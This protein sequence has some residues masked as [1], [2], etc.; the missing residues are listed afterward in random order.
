MLQNQ[1]PDTYPALN[2]AEYSS[3]DNSTVSLASATLPQAPAPAP[4]S[5]AQNTA[6]INHAADAQS[7]SINAQQGFWR[8]GNLIYGGNVLLTQNIRTAPAL[9]GYITAL[10]LANEDLTVYAVNVAVDNLALPGRNVT[11]VAHSV[12]CARCLDS[13]KTGRGCRF[14]PPPA[15]RPSH[16][17]GPTGMET[18]E[19]YAGDSALDP[20]ACGAFD[21]RIV[22]LSEALAE[23][24]GNK[25]I[26]MERGFRLVFDRAEKCRGYGAARS[27]RN[28][29]YVSGRHF[30]AMAPEEGAPLART[31]DRVGCV[32][33]VSQ[34]FLYLQGGGRRIS[35]WV[36]RC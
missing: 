1:S 30:G 35:G 21:K 2:A 6:R 11:I 18:Y 10:V 26:R 33:G 28:S 20:S 9:A 3:S 27:C 16:I 23:Y 31:T 13:P 29:T 7:T 4:G 24:P 25:M 34:H 17:T 5:P 15:E 36:H 14:V 19:A 32:E 22:S 12:F 8:R